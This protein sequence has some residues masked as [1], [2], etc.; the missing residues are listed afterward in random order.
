VRVLIGALSAR[1]YGDRRDRCRRSW[2]ADAARADGVDAVFL[3]GGA[4][5]LT[6][7]GD[8]LHLPCP[9]DYP[10][11]PQKTSWFIQYALDHFDFDFL[12]KCD[13]DTYVSIPRL[14]AS[15][16]PVDYS[17][18]DIG[19]YASGGAGYL[20]GP[21]AARRILAPMRRHARG[22]EDVLVGRA[23]REAGL[24]L[25]PNGRFRSWLAPHEV[26]QPDNDLITA[27]PVRDDL[28]V[29][30]HDELRDVPLQAPSNDLFEVKSW[31][32]GYGVIGLGGNR[33]FAVDGSYRLDTRGIDFDLGGSLTL[34][35]HATSEVTLETR[36]PVAVRGFTDGATFDRPRAPIHFEA[37]GQ[38]LGSLCAGSRRTRE[39]ALHEPGLYTLRARCDGELTRRYS[40]W[41]VRPYRTEGLRIVMPTSNRYTRVAEAS[42]A[43]LDRYWPD[44]PPVD[45]IRHERELA[46]PGA[47]CQHYAGPQSQLTWVE[48]MAWYLEHHNRDELVLLMLDDYALCGPPKREGYAAALEVMRADPGVASYLL[49]WMGAPEKGPY[50][51]RPDTILFPRWAY[52]VNL[53]AAIWRRASLLRILKACGMKVN[54]DT[55][56]IAGTKYFNER[57]FDTETAVGANVAEPPNPSL[58]LDGVEKDGW[59]LPYHNLVHRGVVDGRHAEFLRREGLDVAIMGAD[60]PS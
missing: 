56:E 59:V 30:I 35:A 2:M 38:A 7:S 16:T 22:D 46:A 14:L 21:D 27:H 19:G 58:F 25:T 39:I 50:P 26:P 43:L 42:L 3:L 29:R 31:T 57:E 52:T 45:V 51:G 9:D 36:V 32:T 44:H 54:I 8:E 47:V 10:S 4:R 15:L 34:S 37:G 6:R 17:G 12:F 13:D 48:A 23:V 41:A 49:T 24:K 28:M 20:L 60:P 40:A 53:Q 5:A 1:G 18:N 55:V 11:L 33:G